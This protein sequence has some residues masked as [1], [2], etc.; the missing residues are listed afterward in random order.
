MLDF[1]TENYKF[2]LAHMHEEV[3]QWIINKIH[4]IASITEVKISKEKENIFPFIT[5]GD[6]AIK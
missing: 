3:R 2:A 4:Y 5:N 6:K 1:F